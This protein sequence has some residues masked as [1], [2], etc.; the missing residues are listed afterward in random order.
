MCAGLLATPQL[1]SASA[2]PVIDATDVLTPL[3]AATAVAGGIV[4]GGAAL[5]YSTRGRPMAP[6]F[7]VVGLLSGVA[8]IGMAAHGVYDTSGFNAAPLVGIWGGGVLVLSVVSLSTGARDPA[9]DADRGSESGMW[10]SPTADG[11][12]LGGHF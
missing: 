2:A 12:L 3:A 10:L 4:T 11:L 8:T 9:P 5:A 6:G 7:A 1:A